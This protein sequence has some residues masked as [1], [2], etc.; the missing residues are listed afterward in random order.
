METIEINNEIAEKF[1]F[2]PTKN[3]I[4]VKNSTIKPSHS[5][6]SP[7]AISWKCS[8][9]PGDTFFVST[10]SCIS[11]SS[12]ENARR[13]CERFPVPPCSARVLSKFFP[14]DTVNLSVGGK[15]RAFPRYRSRRG[16]TKEALK[17]LYPNLSGLPVNRPAYFQTPRRVAFA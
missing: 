17:P 16:E 2:R 10:R 15:G 8:V 6:F 12:E 14:V 7:A 3:N 1:Y 5:I 4:R 11:T 13:P 9:S